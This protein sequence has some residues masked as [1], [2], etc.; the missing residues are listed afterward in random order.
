MRCRHLKMPTNV[1]L[2]LGG[3]NFHQLQQLVHSYT[4][5]F[6]LLCLAQSLLWSPAGRAAANLV[7]EDTA[8]RLRL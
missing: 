5:G 4:Q 2:L 3:Q 1:N 8:R 6:L 7:K